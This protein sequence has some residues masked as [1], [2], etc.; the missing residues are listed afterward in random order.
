MEKVNLVFN[1]SHEPSKYCQKEDHSENDDLSGRTEELS[2]TLFNNMAQTLFP[3][4]PTA[5]E[6]HTT[7]LHHFI[8]L[9]IISEPKCEV[10]AKP[11]E[12]GGIIYNFLIYIHD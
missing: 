8:S 12:A 10:I 5:E 1:D 7:E 9:E 11:E 4:L 6:I 2:I 3:I